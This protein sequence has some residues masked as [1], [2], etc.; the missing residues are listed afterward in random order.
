M[1]IQFALSVILSLSI[2]LIPHGVQSET[3]KRGTHHFPSPKLAKEKKGTN[4]FPAPI[5]P[6]TEKEKVEIVKEE[7]YEFRSM[8]YSPRISLIP[9]VNQQ[10]FSNSDPEGAVLSR[11]H[12]MLTGD[13]DK[14]ISSWDSFSRKRLLKKKRT[15][16]DR[17]KIWEK[18]F[19]DKEIFLTS[20]I[21]SGRYVI[22]GIQI[23]KTNAGEIGIGDPRS[24]ES[25][26]MNEIPAVV[27][28]VDGKW[29]CTNELALQR[30]GDPVLGFWSTGKKKLKFQKVIRR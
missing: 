6:T 17:K 20:R 10:R 18:G 14:W 25:R 19:K 26:I 29:F 5:F 22:I 24:T 2:C 8:W 3:S 27:K 23:L 1:K 30:P 16:E 15:P 12:A 4:F 9:L 21:E 13:Y 7:V 28:E 11:Y